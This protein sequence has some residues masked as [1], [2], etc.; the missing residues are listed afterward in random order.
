MEK[1]QNEEL[2]NLQLLG[3]SVIGWMNGVRSPVGTVKGFSSLR[4]L[5]QTGSRAHPT[6]CRFTLGVKWPCR[7]ADHSP[8]SSA[9][10]K[11]VWSYTSTPLYVFM[12][13]YVIKQ[14]I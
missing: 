7:E 1:L 13:W 2:H 6:T 14:G 4:H 9:K 12:A 5:V 11:N 8:Q 10:V 3:S